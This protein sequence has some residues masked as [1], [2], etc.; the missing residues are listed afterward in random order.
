M[1]L[2][3]RDSIELNVCAIVG[4]GDRAY[5]AKVPTTSLIHLTRLWERLGK[6]SLCSVWMLD[7][8]WIGVGFAG[9][10]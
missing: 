4:L 9:A 1:L 3:W 8:Y 7:P 2:D 10:C 6:L 5:Q